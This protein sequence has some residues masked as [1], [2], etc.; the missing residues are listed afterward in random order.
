[1]ERRNRPRRSL[2]LLLTLCALCVWT[3]CAPAAPVAAPTATVAQTA[4]PTRE[5]TPTPSPT[6][7]PTPV[8]DGA[9]DAG[10]LDGYFAG[11]VLVGDSLTGGLNGYIRRLRAAGEPA[12]G[13]ARIVYRSALSLK[14]VAQMERGEYPPMLKY[15]NRSYCLSALIEAMEAERAFLLFGVEDACRYDLETNLAHVREVVEAVRARCPDTELVLLSFPPV[16][17]T[18]ARELDMVGCAPESNAASN[19]AL[20]ALCAELGVGY[21]DL[22]AR[23]RTAGGYLEPSYCLD[24]YFHLNDGGKALWVR[25]LREYARAQYESG[26]WTPAPSPAGA[27]AP[28]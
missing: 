15:R 20:E 1:M 13:E 11:A 7:S 17:E 5:P 24:T 9:L 23:L 21:V 6:P 25:C 18:Y 19:R 22:A 3:A 27:D 8:P 2:C 12:L 16:L 14:Y 10:V 26:R 4:A 28:A